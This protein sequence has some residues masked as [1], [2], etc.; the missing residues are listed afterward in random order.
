MRQFFKFLFASFLGTL[1]ALFVIFFIVVGSIG[2]LASKADQEAPVSA[3]SVLHLKLN[4]PVPELMD[5]VETASFELDPERA[6][7]LRDIIKATSLGM[8]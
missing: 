4:M 5:N 8:R 6:L 7:G 3:N 1:I 2:A